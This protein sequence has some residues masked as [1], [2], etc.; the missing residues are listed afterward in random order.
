MEWE[1]LGGL[2]ATLP[3]FPCFF[4]ASLQRERG[5]KG[6]RERGEGEGREGEGREGR[7]GGREGEGRKGGRERGREREPLYAN[8]S[9][10][11]SHVLCSACAP[12]SHTTAVLCSYYLHIQTDN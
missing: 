1:R 10:S 4:L 3:G 9:T 11:V 2:L 8:P 7:E 5:R 6:G 12:C